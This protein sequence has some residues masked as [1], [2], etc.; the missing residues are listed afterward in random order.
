MR[1]KCNTNIPNV[2]EVQINE[3]FGTLNI[4]RSGLL[5]TC[6]SQLSVI[7]LTYLK[8]IPR[9]QEVA[10]SSITTFQELTSGNGESSPLEVTSAY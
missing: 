9:V 4:L 3:T 8:L 7:N 2:N 5:L 10:P 1:V 6:P